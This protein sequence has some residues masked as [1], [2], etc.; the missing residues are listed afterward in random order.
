VEREGEREA[1]TDEEK[2]REAAK[3]VE[4]MRRLNEQGVIRVLPLDSTQ[5]DILS[6]DDIPLD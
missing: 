5:Q 3:L 2:E 6:S 1:M 4:M